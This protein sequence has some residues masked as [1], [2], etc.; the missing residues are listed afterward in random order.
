[1]NPRLTQAKRERLRLM[2]R[3]L[4]GTKGE[5]KARAERIRA[6]LKTVGSGPLRT[7]GRE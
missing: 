3:S 1:M 2:L 7:T 4:V 5:R 6:E